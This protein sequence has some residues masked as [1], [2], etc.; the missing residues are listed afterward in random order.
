M[1]GL[2]PNVIPNLYRDLRRTM[3]AYFGVFKVKILDIIH[4]HFVLNVGMS[5]NEGKLLPFL[6]LKIYNFPYSDKL[7]EI[8]DKDDDQQVVTGIFER[9]QEGLATRSYLVS[10]LYIDEA[11]VDE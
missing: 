4:F 3:Q 10:L 1:Q 2:K 11:L 6:C 9:F 5:S 7:G 8:L